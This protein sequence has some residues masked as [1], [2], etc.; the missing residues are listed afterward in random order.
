MI[1]SMLFEMPNICSERQS[2]KFFKKML[3]QYERTVFYK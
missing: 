2:S 1:S 3:E